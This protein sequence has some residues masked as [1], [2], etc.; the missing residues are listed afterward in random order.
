MCLGPFYVNSKNY[1]EYFFGSDNGKDFKIT[2]NKG[3]KLY[4]VSPGLTGESGSMSIESADNPGFYLRHYKYMIE[5][6]SRANGRDKDTFDQ[7]ATFFPRANKFFRSFYSLESSNYPDHF[8]RH[9][10]NTLRISKQDKSE[11]FKN[12]AS[13]RLMTQLPVRRGWCYI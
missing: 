11:L 2:K 13:F 3:I 1:D 10:G 7:D 6:E 4:V 8:I 12:D 5:L 9:Q